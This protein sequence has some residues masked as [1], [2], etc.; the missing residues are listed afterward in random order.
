MGLCGSSE[1]V[2]PDFIDLSHFEIMRVVGKGGFGK[3]NAITKKDTGELFALKRLGKQAILSSGD[4]YLESVWTERRIMSLCKSPF[5]CHLIY[6]FQTNRELFLVM[7]FCQGGDLRYHMREHGPLSEDHARFY[8]AELLCGLA[9]LHAKRVVFRDLKPDNILLDAEGHVRI[10]DFGLGYELNEPE[11]YVICSQAGTRGYQ[12][13]EVINDE[14]FGCEAD[15]FSYGIT[16]YELL[17]GQR[18][19]KPNDPEH[20]SS[21][22]THSL[23]LSSRLSPSCA[24]LLRGLLAVDRFQRLGCSNLHRFPND[25]AR[26]TVNWDEVAEHPWFAGL[27]FRGVVYKRKLKPPFI[28]DSERANCSPD[29]E[30]Y[31]QLLDHKPKPVTDPELARKFDGWEFNTDIH[32]KAQQEDARQRKD[33]AGAA[34]KPDPDPEQQPLRP[35]SATATATEQNRGDHAVQASSSYGAFGESNNMQGTA[36]VPNSAQPASVQPGSSPSSPEADLA[37]TFQQESAH[38]RQQQQQQQNHHEEALTNGHGHAFGSAHDD[39]DEDEDD[40]H[41]AAV[42]DEDVHFAIDENRP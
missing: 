15:V 42:D 23:A 25:A 39:G 11:G 19:W 38:Q 33:S 26:R 17:H 2:N 4:G 37:A 40:G 21:P 29:A 6:A 28:P 12:A 5:L 34:T 41:D 10:S 30:L 13:P 1:G 9:D 24:S 22:L 8:A 35:A 27:D 32:Q 20:P 18:P 16:L 31:D 36:I 3:V 14:Y 7:P